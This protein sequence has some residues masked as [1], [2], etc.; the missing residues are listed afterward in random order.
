MI[1]TA[2]Q[3]IAR[4][5]KSRK[6]KCKDEKRLQVL[7]RK[8]GRKSSTEKPSRVWNNTRMDPKE[9]GF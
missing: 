6:M 5:I 1:C 3:N 8:P 2:H 7:V 4:A 9:I